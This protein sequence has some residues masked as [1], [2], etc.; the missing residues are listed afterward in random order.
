VNEQSFQS[1]LDSHV[2][3]ILENQDKSALV[4]EGLCHL[5]YMHEEF[6]NKF[7]IKVYNITEISN[8]S[9]VHDH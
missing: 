5:I 8:L 4:F 7:T 6:S 1:Q 9:I 2:N 3:H